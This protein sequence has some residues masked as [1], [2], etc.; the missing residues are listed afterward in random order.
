MEGSGYFPHQLL[1]ILIQSSPVY[2]ALLAVRR[3]TKW[4]RKKEWIDSVTYG[5]MAHLYIIIIIHIHIQ[6]SSFF[7]CPFSSSYSQYT[8]RRGAIA[9]RYNRIFNTYKCMH[10]STYPALNVFAKRRRREEQT[11]ENTSSNSKLEPLVD[12]FKLSN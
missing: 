9:T 1:P 5:S 11:K 6:S 12:S 10:V 4:T 3:Y 8:K 7:L 2:R